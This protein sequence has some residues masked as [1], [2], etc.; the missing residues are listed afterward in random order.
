MAT[1]GHGCSVC[2]A[3][4]QRVTRV[5]PHLLK[6]FLRAAADP[7]T[8]PVC[9]VQQAPPPPGALASSCTQSVASCGQT[10]ERPTVLC[11]ASFEQHRDELA[12]AV[13]LIS[14]LY[15]CNTWAYFSCWLPCFVCGPPSTA[16]SQQRR[17]EQEGRCGAADGA[18]CASYA[19]SHV[20]R[21]PTRL[22]QAA[23]AV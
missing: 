3:W 23:V 18:P 6:N 1:D 14:A 20:E 17:P 15:L 12:S 7:P 22:V 21:M 5:C 8:S 10:R 2:R 11:V 16:S 19:G 9:I 13:A 4:V